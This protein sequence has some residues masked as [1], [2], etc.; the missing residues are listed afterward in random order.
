MKRIF[1]SASILACLLGAAVAQ[2]PN[3]GQPD[4]G[5]RRA[6]LGCINGAAGDPGGIAACVGTVADPC[7]ELPENQST[8]MMGACINRELVIWDEQMNEIYGSLLEALDEE[9]G[10]AL[11]QSQRAWIK[12]RDTSCAFSAMLWQG[13][14]GAGPA[15]GACFNRET[16]TRVAFLSEAMSMA[17]ER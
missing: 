1:V 11:R 5:E 8:V 7:L 12:M 6:L 10:K 3:P 14:T 2:E 13:G 16:A 9:T 4:R 17:V 15:A